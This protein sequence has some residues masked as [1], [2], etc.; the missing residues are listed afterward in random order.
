MTNHT[1]EITY[2]KPSQEL[3]AIAKTKASKL[4][5]NTQIRLTADTN[6]YYLFNTGGIL[7]IGVNVKET[8]T[9]FFKN[10]PT[11]QMIDK[12]GIVIY[13]NLQRLL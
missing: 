7:F 4:P 6:S 2:T 10:K 9:K 8:S 12:D 13:T 11:M 1:F 3:L 5:T